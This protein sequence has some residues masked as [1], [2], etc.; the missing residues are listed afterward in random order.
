M[1][2][3]FSDPALL[4]EVRNLARAMTTTEQLPQIDI[5]Q[6]KINLRRLKDA[7]ILLYAQQEALR[8]RATVPGPRMVMED[9]IVGDN[10]YLLKKGSIVIIASKALRFD[11]KT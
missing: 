11:E 3:I 7:P 2:R 9:M 4:E 6:S 10:Q 5:F 8:F 1:I